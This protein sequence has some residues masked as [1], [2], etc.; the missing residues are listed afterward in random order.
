VRDFS[1]TV[2]RG[3]KIGLIGD[4]GTGKTTLLKLIL[5][6]LEPTRG[7][8]RR[9]TLQQV[10]YFDQMREGLNLDATLADTISNTS[11]FVTIGEQRK[12]VMS[13][14]ND[15]LFS[16]ARANAPV[17]TLSGGERN[18][19][20]L[21]R[22]FARPANV[23]VLDEPTNDL[24]IDT[25]ELLEA[26]LQ[27]YK[28]TVF[29]VSHDRRFLDNVVT[30][31]LVAEGDGRWQEY[32]GGV[33][34][35]LTQ[36]GRVLGE[37]VKATIKADPKADIPLPAK[38]SSAAPVAQPSPPKRKLGYKDQRELD[39]LPERIAALEQEQTQ[40]NAQMASANF[41]QEGAERI[42]LVH[43]RHAALEIELMQ[44]LERWTVLAG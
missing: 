15:F 2:L 27:D 19:L 29:I 22:L 10:A 23:L 39:A 28:G 41:Y 14:L 26:L 17:K 16:P 11:E 21:A 35:W 25:L 3:D 36:S 31:T 32:E 18:R 38:A 40:L 37:A 24:D 43:A 13:Y 5:G 12:H 34:D 8:V 33:S 44:C 9:G 42:A 1:C 4:N 20:L 7:Q 6:D 30:S